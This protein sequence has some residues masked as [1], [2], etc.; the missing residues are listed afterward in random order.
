MYHCIKEKRKK[1]T[2]THNIHTL[3]TTHTTQP[4]TQEFSTLLKY[5]EIYF[6]FLNENHNVSITNSGNRNCYQSSEHHLV[7]MATKVYNYT[8]SISRFRKL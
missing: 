3:N 5:L 4:L 1:N 8:Y 6:Q 2:E 7:P